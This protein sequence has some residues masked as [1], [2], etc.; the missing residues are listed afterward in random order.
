MR[1]AADPR[2]QEHTWIWLAKIASGVLV[3]AI[4]AI[5]LAVNH[6]V[7][8]GGLL[9]YADVVAYY[10]NPIVP[11]IEGCFLVFVVCHA[12]LGVR[13][14]ALDLNP[15]A[16]MVRIMDIVLAALGVAAIGYGLGLLATIASRA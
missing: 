1:I 2:P 4:L 12:L 16:A 14:I 8:S 11:L 5:H 9:T 7:A 3:F 15:S 10:A 13:G 6:M